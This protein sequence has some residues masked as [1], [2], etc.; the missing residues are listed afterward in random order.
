M[1]KF[2]QLDSNHGVPSELS[3]F[4]PPWPH[5]IWTAF[6]SQ[7]CK[8]RENSSTEKSPVKKSTWGLRMPKKWKWDEMELSKW[9][10][11]YLKDQFL[12]KLLFNFWPA[13]LFLFLV[14][15]V[16]LLIASLLFLWILVLVYY[17]L[18]LLF[19]FFAF[20]SPV[21]FPNRDKVVSSFPSEVFSFAPHFSQ[22]L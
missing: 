6:F 17:T 22:I 11:S 14:L 5:S 4:L 21:I 18:L 2:Y 9:C 1:L 3:L 16:Q 15:F 12:F 8:A 10:I 19:L 7:W 20:L 13:A